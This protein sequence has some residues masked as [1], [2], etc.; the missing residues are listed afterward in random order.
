MYAFL[1]QVLSFT[2]TDLESGYAYGKMLSRRI[3]DTR[4]TSL[5]LSSELE[6][7]HVRLVDRGSADLSLSAEET[8][9]Y[10]F[11]G[12]GAG[13]MTEDEQVL[14]S[15]IVELINE[16]Y[17][18]D[19]TDADKVFFQGIGETMADDPELQQQASANTE[20]NFQFAFEDAFMDAVVEGMERNTDLAKKLLDDDR[21]ADIVK[22]W[23]LRYVHR[24]AQQKHDRPELALGTERAL[25]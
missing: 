1:A 11:A 18:A 22:T 23:L 7:T 17:G 19:L 6:L 2:D 21:F 14:L 9:Q 24:R 13:P 10:A 5:D 20:E 8:E 25:Q 3:S 15:E 16:K 4:G 12:E